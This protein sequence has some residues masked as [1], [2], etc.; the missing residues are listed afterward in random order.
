MNAD[1]SQRRRLAAGRWA[2]WSPT[3]GR[4]AFTRGPSE[5]EGDSERA[6]LFAVGIRGGRALSLGPV[7]GDGYAWAPDGLR[8]AVTRDRPCLRAGVYIVDLRARSRSL[9][10]DCRIRG[11]SRSDVLH[12]TKEP[13]LV[14]GLAGDDTI[15][16]NPGDKFKWGWGGDRDLVWGGSGDDH[17]RTGPSADLIYGGPG[18]DTLDGDAEADAIFGGAGDD[19]L[20][21]DSYHDRLD[22]GRGHD[23]LIGG[24]GVDLLM[25]ADGARDVLECGRGRDRATVDRFDRVKRDCERVSIVG[26]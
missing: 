14:W 11:S 6:S 7:V 13:D 10:N 17:I 23:R 5:L 19:V 25:A 21:G 9:T 2:R 12:G 16:S 3:G 8:L 26:R 20:R 22:G 18:A 15:D 1:G 4:I 24:A